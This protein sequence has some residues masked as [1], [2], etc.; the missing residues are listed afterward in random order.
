MSGLNI[1]ILSFVFASLPH[2]QRPKVCSRWLS[3]LG[4]LINRRYLYWFIIIIIQN[5]NPPRKQIIKRVKKSL[6]QLSFFYICSIWLSFFQ[7]KGKDNSSM[8]DSA[9][10][11]S[12]SNSKNPF[13]FRKYF[14]VFS[15]FVIIF[16]I[17][18]HEQ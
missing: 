4:W 1:S 15:S 12:W 11:S 7:R 16:W 10:T 8:K 3:N 18:D 13:V 17:N 5:P 2:L 9:F 14:V 6:A